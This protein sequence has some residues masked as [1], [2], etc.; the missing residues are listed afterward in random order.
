MPW[1]P[2]SF[3]FSA[4]GRQV[5]V[6]ADNNKI[7]LYDLAGDNLTNEKVLESHRGGVTA[8]AFSPDGRYLASGDK[9]REIFIWQ[10]GRVVIKDWQYHSAK[11]NKIAWSPDSKFIA[12]ASLDTNIIVW[13]LE[14][15]ILL[16]FLSHG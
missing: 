11:V 13:S 8:L 1:T 4:D 12:S 5:A 10:D 3:A 2:Q 9:N 7:Y 16:P 6:G 14:V 15:F